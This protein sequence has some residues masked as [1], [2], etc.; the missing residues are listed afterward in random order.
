L[1]RVKSSGGLNRIKAS[2]CSTDAKLPEG[3][4]INIDLE[5]GWYAGTLWQH[6][7]VNGPAKIEEVPKIIKTDEEKAKFV[8]GWLMGEKKVCIR[9][10]KDAKYIYLTKEEQEK[11][12]KING[13][14]HA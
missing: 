1:N 7:A 11:F 5:Y 13:A 6:L 4:D 3:T 14:S 8:S 9:N 10:A 12:H 2:S